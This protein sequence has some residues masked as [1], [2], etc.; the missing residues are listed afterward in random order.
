MEGEGIR[1]EVVEITDYLFRSH[2][3]FHVDSSFKKLPTGAIQV[4][5]TNTIIIASKKTG[6]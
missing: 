6:Q 2:G 1:R 3:G 4:R 5:T